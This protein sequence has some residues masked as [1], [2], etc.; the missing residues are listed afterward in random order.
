MNYS[1][2]DIKRALWTAEKI[3]HEKDYLDKLKAACGKR[4]QVIKD[5]KKEVANRNA[6]K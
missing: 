6:N 2:D 5:T 3:K 1:V 4:E